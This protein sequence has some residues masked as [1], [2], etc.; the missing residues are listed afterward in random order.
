MRT[1]FLSKNS[2]EA[3]TRKE[4]GRSFISK[5]TEKHEV[6]ANNPTIP[7]VFKPQS[8]VGIKIDFL[9][10]NLMP[11]IEEGDI[12]LVLNALKQ[13]CDNSFAQ[14][15]G[16]TATFQLLPYGTFPTDEQ[17]AGRALIYLADQLINGEVNFSQAV[18]AHWVTVPPPNDTADGDGP[19][20]SFLIEGAPKIPSN[21]I[22]M[23][24]PYGNANYGLAAVLAGNT[25]INTLGVALSHEVFET[26]VDPYP[27]GFGASYQVYV[28]ASYTLM[29]VKEVC[30]PVEN[31]RTSNINGITMANFVYPTYFNP[32][33]EVGCKL[34]NNNVITSPLTPHMGMQ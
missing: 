24:I 29:Y 5:N 25:L 4:E 8:R 26:I 16:C 15:W 18:G 31:S 9:V 1:K 11:Q 30:D 3:T 28:G 33:S 17:I 22:I 10:I 21:T 23:M 2:K 34:D 14:V 20:P 32:L 27:I 12:N 7:N 19:Q 6:E 13:Y